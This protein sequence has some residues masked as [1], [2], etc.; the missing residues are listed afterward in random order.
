MDK[1][2]EFEK[3]VLQWAYRMRRKY[4]CTEEVFFEILN[5]AETEAKKALRKKGGI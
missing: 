5:A 1:E 4:G 3:L 2:E